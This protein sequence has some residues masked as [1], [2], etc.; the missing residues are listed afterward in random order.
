M[1]FLLTNENRTLDHYLS[2]I[3]F[4]GWHRQAVG[5]KN[6]EDFLRTRIARK[7]PITEDLMDIFVP[8]NTS[9]LPVNRLRA[10]SIKNAPGT[11]ARTRGNAFP[12]TE[13]RAANP[14]SSP[15]IEPGLRPSQSRV[16]IRHTPRTC[17]ADDWIRTSM[18]RLT[19]PAPFLVAPRRR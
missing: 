13:W 1:A 2:R 19:K 5:G 9:L 15:G 11:M 7:P 17:R 8:Q 14:A 3:H 18:N 12:Q 6:C 4:P 16:R 10:R